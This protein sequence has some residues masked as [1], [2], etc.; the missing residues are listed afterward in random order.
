M[1][2]ESITTKDGI[3]LKLKELFSDEIRLERAS[4]SEFS[5]IP[6]FMINFENLLTFI[7]ITSLQEKTR[8]E[9]V[10]WKT[11]RLIE[12]LFE[13]KLFFGN[14][15]V[16]LLFILDSSLWKPYCLELL[17]GLFDK[18]LYDFNTD[19]RLYTKPKESNFKLW[20]LEREF[21]NSR[22]KLLEKIN[23]NEFFYRP[24]SNLEFEKIVF[25]KLHGLNFEL[26]RNYGVRNLKNYYLKQDMNLKFYFDFYINDKIVEVKSFKKMNT[27]SIQNLLIKSRLIR[28]QKRNGTI[29]Q[30]PTNEMILIING[31]V[32]G[33]EYDKMRYLRMLTTAGWNVHSAKILS[34]KRKMREVFSNAS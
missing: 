1:L 3:I 29:K 31:D 21:N 2:N 13:A 33:P 25:E 6:D 19:S 5:F 18:V 24:M 27:R 22:Y 20:N 32:S 28:Y 12:H 23:L 34:N 14:D 16:F 8:M 26:H 9:N 15:S 7:E 30:V 11:L 4:I 17:E 10:D